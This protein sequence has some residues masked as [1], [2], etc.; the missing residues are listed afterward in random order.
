MENYK[1]IVDALSSTAA[2]IAILT[3]LISWYKK[4]VDPDGWT[5]KLTS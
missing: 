5:H 3:V 2:F 4:E 1:Y